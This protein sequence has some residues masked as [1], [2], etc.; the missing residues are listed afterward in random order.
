MSPNVIGIAN[1]MSANK[2]AG[3]GSANTARS[4][5]RPPEHEVQQADVTEL[6]HD[7][8]A[9]LHHVEHVRADDHPADEQPDQPG[10]VDALREPGRDDDHDDRD[11]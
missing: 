9:A 8:T 1:V 4:R 10:N 5:S 11:Q 2:I 6:L 3:C 7:A